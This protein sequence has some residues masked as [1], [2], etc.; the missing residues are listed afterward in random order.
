MPFFSGLEMSSILT[1]TTDY[2]L[3]KVRFSANESGFPPGFHG[4]QR[5]ATPSPGLARAAFASWAG[6]ALVVSAIWRVLQE[7]S[8]RI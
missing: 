4:L 1:V 7:S 8:I 2:L 5:E 6:A 3:W